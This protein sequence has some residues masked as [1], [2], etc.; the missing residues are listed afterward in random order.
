MKR[1]GLIVMFLFAAFGLTAC[2]SQTPT[3]PSGA[4]VGAAAGGVLHDDAE[5]SLSARLAASPSTIGAGQSS[6]LTWTTQGAEHAYLDGVEVARS[7]SKS[8]SPSA[9]KT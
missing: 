3:A 5:D 8:V 9:T 1:V 6:T 2:Q 4:A 7:G